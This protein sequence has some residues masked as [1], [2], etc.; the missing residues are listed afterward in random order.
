MLDVTLSGTWENLGS[1]SYSITTS[2]G[3]FVELVFFESNT[4]YFQ[5]VEDNGTPGDT[6]DDV[7]EKDVYIKQ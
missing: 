1:N 5:Y 4:F 7:V 2:A 6:S 3:T